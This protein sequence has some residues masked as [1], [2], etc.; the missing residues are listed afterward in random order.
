MHGHMNV[1]SRDLS[2]EKQICTTLKHKSGKKNNQLD[3]HFSWFIFNKMSKYNRGYVRT[4]SD[5]IT[6][7]VELLRREEI[8]YK[9]NKKS[10]GTYLL[11]YSDS[12][13]FRQHKNSVISDTNIRT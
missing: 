12:H 4:Y 9:N 8:Y 2:N 1:K 7:D 3:S 6:H 13:Y 5:V 10:L 11:W